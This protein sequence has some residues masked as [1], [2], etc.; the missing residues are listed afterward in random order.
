MPKLKREDGEPRAT[1][2]VES[3]DRGLRLLQAFGETHSADDAERN[4]ARRRSAA[5]HRAPH[6]VHAAARRLRL[7]RRQAVRADAACAD[8]GRPLSALEPARGGAAAGAGPHLARQ[9]RRSARSPCST[10]TTSCSS[11]ARARRASSPAASISA[12]ACRRFCTAVGRAMLG[13]LSDAEL[14]EKLGR[15]AARGADAADGDRSEAPASPPS[16]PIAAAAIRWSTAR[17]SRI[18][19]RSRCRCS[20]TTTPSSPPSISAPM[21]TASRPRRW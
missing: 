12:I 3:L 19:A 17:P 1:D 16:P 14:K 5:R 11:R 15:D 4:R 2:F 13:R 18:S 7:E 21:S 10:A 6:P 9:R 8:A 20:A